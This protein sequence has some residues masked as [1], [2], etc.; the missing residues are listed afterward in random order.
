M[1]QHLSGPLPEQHSATAQKSLPAPA[2]TPLGV[3]GYTFADLHDS[4][5]LASL[6][7][8][9]CEEVQAPDPVFWTKG[10]AY[11]K[12]PD[13]PR[14]PLELSS[15][16]VSMAPYV[17]RFIAR[18]FSIGDAASVLTGATHSQDDLFRF[19]VD[20]VRRRALPL[21]KGKHATSTPDDDALVSRLIA[22]QPDRELA[23]A[24]A[25][26][27]LMDAEK[28]QVEG[29]KSQDVHAETEALK[30][31]CDARLQDP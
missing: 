23:I 3:S 4:E 2:T 8:R 21:A 29:H 19:K 16:I 31:W 13:A 15:L 11:R 24:R 22:G 26:C 30:R 27:R 25:G 9:F 17:S 6:Y 14:P 1:P 5:R 12:D 10:D 7:E 28:S 20:F 18:L